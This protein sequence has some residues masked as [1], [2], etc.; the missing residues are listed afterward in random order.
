MPARTKSLFRMR[1]VALLLLV[2]VAVSMAGV[3]EGR[4]KG[5]EERKLCRHIKGFFGLLCACHVWVSGTIVSVL[6]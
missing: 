2:M 4:P 6:K 3:L 1:N 5:D